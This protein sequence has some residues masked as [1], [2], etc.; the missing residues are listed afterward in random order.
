MPE[1]RKKPV[2]DGRVVIKPT[3]RMSDIL[4]LFPGAQTVLEAYGLYCATCAFGGEESLEEGCRVHGFSEVDIQELL[5]DL[6]D[7][8]L[9]EPPRSQDLNVTPQTVEGLK[10]LAKNEG[11]EGE[12]LRVTLDQHGAFCM[13]FAQE[14][15]KD[16][17]VFEKDGLRFL[18]S[19]LALHR[20]GGALIDWR[21]GSFTLDLE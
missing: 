6:N 7:A 4:T 5:E 14:K 8:L 1:T 2:Q 17:N 20:I 9:R 16:D 11:H 19:P 3:M 18:V 12:Y 13:E 15:K 10:E 21:E